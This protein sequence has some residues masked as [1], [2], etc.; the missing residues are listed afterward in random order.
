MSLVL[1]FLI[2][3]FPPDSHDLPPV[4]FKA[5]FGRF[6]GCFFLQELGGSVTIQYNAVRC[7]QRFAP[8]STFKIFNAMAGLDCGVLADE[9][10]TLEWDGTAQFVKAWEHD[11][12]LATAIRDSVLWYFREVAGR[13]GTERMQRY[14]DRCDYGNRRM[15]GQLRGFWLDD[16]LRISAREQAKF[17]ARLYAGA[18]PFSRRSQDLV[19]RLI[20][21]DRGAGWVFSGKTGTQMTRDR[22]TLGWFVGH[23]RS[24]GREFVFAANLSADDGASGAATKEIVLAILKDLALVE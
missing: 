11:H 18:L 1:S 7:G 13:I 4:D 17:L 2:A 16:S 5:R 14:L 10:A 15:G 21:L 23:V 12:T 6:D 22:R 20:I 8:C 9:H 3:L 24:G 19:R